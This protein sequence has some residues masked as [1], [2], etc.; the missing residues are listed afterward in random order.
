MNLLI[1]VAYRHLTQMYEEMGNRGEALRVFARCR[2]SYDPH[3]PLRSPAPYR[4]STSCPAAIIGRRPRGN[5]I[6]S[7]LIL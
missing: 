3:A 2:D 7:V 5:S 1:E 6:P 4:V